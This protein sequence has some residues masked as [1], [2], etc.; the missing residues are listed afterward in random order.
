MKVVIGKHPPH[1]SRPTDVKQDEKWLFYRKEGVTSG[2]GI[3]WVC[4]DCMLSATHADMIPCFLKAHTL[5][6]S[7]LSE[8]WPTMLMKSPLLPMDESILCVCLYVYAYICV[9][10]VRQ[11]SVLYLTPTALTS[12]ET[13]SRKVHIPSKIFG[14]FQPY[15]CNF[16]YTHTH[17]K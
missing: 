13:S 17:Q 5:S 12:L 14:T 2:A 9:Y 4:S 16:L 15:F 11:C 10:V 1:R 8:R 7:H 6:V 3:K